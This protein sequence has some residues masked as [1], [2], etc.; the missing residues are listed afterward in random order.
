MSFIDED[1]RQKAKLREKRNRQDKARRVRK[2]KKKIAR[3]ALLLA[4]ADLQK[5][6]GLSGRTTTTFRKSCRLKHQHQ[7]RV[8]TRLKC[9]Y[10]TPYDFGTAVPPETIPITEKPNESFP[11]ISTSDGK[12]TMQEMEDEDDCQIFA[13]DIRKNKVAIAHASSPGECFNTSPL[14]QRH[15]SSSTWCAADIA[16]L[17]GLETEREDL[18]DE[19]VVH[20]AEDLRK[21]K[22]AAAHASNPGEYL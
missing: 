19:E 18:I 9:W 5:S 22:V 7:Q 4:W 10:S 13:E 3:D 12:V 6:N 1:L 14:R 16:V 20:N 8:T 17:Q 21:P 11:I 2:V 15:V